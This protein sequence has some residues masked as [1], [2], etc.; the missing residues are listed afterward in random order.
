[1]HFEHEESTMVE[2]TPG[3][4]ANPL[5]ATT[6]VVEP[7]VKAQAI[8]QFLVGVVLVAIAGAVTDGNLLGEL[9]DAVTA[10]LAPVLPVLV[11]FAAAYRARHQFRTPDSFLDR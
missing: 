2:D 1:M 10:I 11:G 9:P 5:P 8:V 4:A 7:K 3:T 6:T